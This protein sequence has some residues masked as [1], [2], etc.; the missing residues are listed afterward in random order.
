M[1]VAVRTL[2]VVSE[3]PLIDPRVALWAA[4]L[5]APTRRSDRA[6]VARLR[7]AV[8]TDMP[9]VDAAAR[10]WTQLGGGLDATRCRVV[11]RVGWVRA[12][13]AALDGAFE[14]LADKLQTDRRVASRVVGAQVGALLGLLS[15]KVLGQ[16]VLPLAAPGTGQLVVV[17]P[18][19]LALEEEFGPLAADIRRTVLVHE[20][21]H[22]LQFE[23]VGWMGDHLRGLLRR[24]LSH[25]KIDASALLDVAGRLPGAVADARAA[26]SVQP[27]IEAVMSPEQRDVMH[28]A[29][30]LMSLLE[31]HGNAAMFLGSAGVVED[32]EAVRDALQ[33]RRQDAVAKVLT[34][35]AGL[36]MKKRQYREGEA[37]VRAV[38]DE[39]GIDGL[40]R[41]F[42][43]PENLPGAAEVTAP[44]SWVERV[45]AA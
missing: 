26:G 10:D 2:P 6:A 9:E 14:P 39:V 31:G 3:P 15:T 29:Q 12:N 4:R 19:L 7:A 25:A 38:V 24:Y 13:L 44:H 37:F 30:G 42:A 32:P 40:N 17:G 1:L 33:Q 27:L 18:N 23:G 8:A 11:G 22:R 41:A 36:E 5:A 21:T 28:E 45:V 20:V 16:Y 34:A 35:V 43:A